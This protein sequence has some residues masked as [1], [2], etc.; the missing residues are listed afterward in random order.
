MINKKNIHIYFLLIKSEYHYSDNDIKSVDLISQEYL[1]FPVEEN[2]HRNSYSRP[3][4]IGSIHSS[5]EFQINPGSENFYPMNFDTIYMETPVPSNIESERTQS[6]YENPNPSFRNSIS[7]ANL[8]EQYFNLLESLSKVKRKRTR[9]SNT[10]LSNKLKSFSRNIT[11]RENN[12]YRDQDS[13]TDVSESDFGETT[14]GGEEDLENFISKV[15]LSDP[16]TV[17][18]GIH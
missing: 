4:L 12:F 13:K 3:S 5:M 15:S 8:S 18:P 2:N 9:N 16:T 14:T 7:S 1:N 11:T 17:K 10:A 6:E